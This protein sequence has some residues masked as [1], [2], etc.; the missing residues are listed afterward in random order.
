MEVTLEESTDIDPLPMKTQYRG[1][2]GINCVLFLCLT[3]IWLL[4]PPANTSDRQMLYTPPLQPRLSIYDWKNPPTEVSSSAKDR[5]L[6]FP[7]VEQRIQFYMSSWFSPPCD[8]RQLISVKEIPTK[9]NYTLYQV[10]GLT[11]E[12]LGNRSVTQ[13]QLSS[14]P[15]A[16]TVFA[17]DDAQ[18]QWCTGY[19]YMPRVNGKQAAELSGKMGKAYC[20]DLIQALNLYHEISNSSARSN[21]SQSQIALPPLFAQ[22]GDSQWSLTRPHNPQ[23][24]PFVFP[25]IP[26]LAKTRPA[27]PD[28]FYTPDASSSLCSSSRKTTST[29]K[30]M[31]H[32]GNL[33]RILWKLNTLRHYQNLDNNISDW[34]SSIPWEAKLNQSVFRGADTGLDRIRQE[35]RRLPVDESCQLLPRCRLCRNT[36]N[37]SLVD[38][39]LVKRYRNIYQA[40]YYSHRLS[41]KKQLSYKG[42]IVVP[43]ND[44]ATGLKWSMLSNSVV[45]MPRP[46]ISSWF[47]EEWLQPY[48]HYVPLKD[49]LS[50]AEEQT[51]WM[52]NHPRQ[53]QRIAQRGSMW[54]RDMLFHEK[55]AAE[56]LR[57]QGEILRRY[58]RFFAASS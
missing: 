7:S 11:L 38:A 53:S 43:G 51:R 56:E 19:A 42:I 28:A 32:E 44:V 14:Q 40:S 34:G 22:S 17:L 1:L 20:P 13:L 3:Q 8:E 29:P 37:S 36:Q 15:R 33:P 23:M 39:K 55:A 47:M 24:L 41:I 6:R 49:D 21:S 30:M 5:K 31:L 12:G 48:I 50:D 54:V 2:I 4:H 25:T 58:Q 10:Q 52:L 57:I 35:L 45:L 26:H 9:E 16:D 18:L 27:L 46:R